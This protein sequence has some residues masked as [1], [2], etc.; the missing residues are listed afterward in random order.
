MERIPFRTVSVEEVDNNIPLSV[1]KLIK[2]SLEFK[3]LT[4]AQMDKLDF[5]IKNYTYGNA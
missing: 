4:P 2:Y 3:H 5:F 1:T